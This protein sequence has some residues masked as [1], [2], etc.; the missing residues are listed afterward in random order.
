M[1]LLFSPFQLRSV[2]LKNRIVVSPMC[3]YSAHD[4]LAND[5]HLVH[6]GSRAVGG[7]GLVLTEAVAVTP[8]GRI[9]SADLGLW[10]DEQV[11]PLQRIT[12]FLDSQGAVPG[13]QLAHAGRKASMTPPWLG[14]HAVPPAEGGWV[15]AGPGNEPFHPDGVPPTALTADEIKG[16]AAAFGTAAARACKAG[17]KLIEIHGAHG[18]LVHEFLSPLVNRRTDEYG[19]AFD[20]R[21]RFLREVAAAIRA[22]IPADMP[23]LLRISATDWH[24]DGWQVAD[25]VH[26]GALAAEMGIDLIDCSSGGSINGVKIPAK[27]NYQVPFAEEVRK[28]G[29]PTGAVGII[30]NALQA[31]TILEQGKAD[32]IFMARE[33]LRNPYF[34]LTAAAELGDDLAWP[35]QYER[36]KRV[37]RK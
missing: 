30:V 33:L 26:L 11:A 7:A 6:L 20:N 1:S 16:L 28:S 9:S 36:A 10:N 17:F 15:P 32:L 3:Q 21:L 23:L 29:I 35:V 24:D 8:E 13:I 18:Y 25:S 4:G 27:P 37:V 5:W 31:E 2:R 34:P 12:R 19:G 22:N 14:D